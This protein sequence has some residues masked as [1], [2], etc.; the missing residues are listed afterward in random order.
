MSRPIYQL[1]VTT[2]P[3]EA[4]VKVALIGRDIRSKPEEIAR[5][6]LSQH[7]GVMEDVATIAESI[8]LADRLFPRLRGKVW[9]RVI[10]LQIPVFELVT[11]Q[12]P[13]VLASLTDAIHF[14]TGDTWLISFVRRPGY[15]LTQ[16]ILPF[17]RMTYKYVTPYSDGLDSFAQ[18]RLLEKE[19]GERSVLKLRSA[20]IGQDS[21]ELQRPV[22]RVPRH[23]G[24][25]HKAEQ[26]YRSRPFVFFSFAGIGAFVSDADAV[27]IGETGQGALGPAMIRYAD[28]WPFR[29]T[30]PGFVSRL[31]R[32]LSLVFGKE[33]AFRLPQL[34]RTKGEVL[35][36]LADE[37]LLHGWDETKSCSVRPNDRHGAPVCGICG[38]CVLRSLAISSAEIAQSEPDCAFSLAAPEAVAASGK[39]MTLAERHMAVRSLGTMAELA[40]L[41]G[42]ARG[43]LLIETESMLFE[44][45]DSTHIAASL[46]DLVIRHDAEWRSFAGRLPQGGWA[47]AIVD[48]L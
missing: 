46:R 19:A 36:R 3:I 15:P 4:T 40:R 35:R 11:F 25:M 32:Y 43:Q 29:S 17:E 10:E 45:K 14:L 7:R 18:S 44:Q 39:A 41:A 34:W 38:G 47:H 23:L 21:V 24:P 13:K 6:C 12:K 33:I 42:N 26:T 22:L 5:Y 1:A 16:Q 28:E 48:Q 20:K 31:S 2:E 8:A 37:N 27:V 9:A 30:H